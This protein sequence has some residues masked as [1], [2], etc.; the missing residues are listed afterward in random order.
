MNIRQIAI[1]GAG[2]WGTALAV[3]WSK[4]GNEITLWGHDPARTE[5]VRATRE[6]P[7]YLPGIKLPESIRVTS[8]IADCASADL[9][10]FVTPSIALRSCRP[11]AAC[12]AL[13]LKGCAFEWHKRHRTRHR[14]E[15]E[16]D[17]RG[18]FPAK[19][20]RRYFRPQSGR[21]S[22]T[23]ASHRHCSRLPDRGM[24]R[25]TSAASWERTLPHLFER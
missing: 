7:D 11:S 6:N 5:K 12:L 20:C 21:G 16:P 23:R 15:D 8:D 18:D 14:H 24:R 3:L 13:R 2:G 25:G 22:F 10:V 4:Q 1:V 19:H 9:I 17:S